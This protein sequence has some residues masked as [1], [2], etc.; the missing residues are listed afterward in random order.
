MSS[1]QTSKE[2]ELNVL[3]G[4][5]EADRYKDASALCLGV[6][7]GSAAVIKMSLSDAMPQPIGWHVV[8]RVNCPLIVCH[9]KSVIQA[10]EKFDQEDMIEIW[11]GK[12]NLYT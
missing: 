5:R 8:A 7:W 6:I 10:A 11:I 1:Q 9:M 12:R 3:H 2:K 4:N